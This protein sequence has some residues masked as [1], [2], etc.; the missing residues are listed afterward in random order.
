LKEIGEYLRQAREEKNIS[1]KDVQ[2]ATKISM[3][4]LEAIERGDFNGIPGEVYCKGFIANYA[5]AI[6]LDPQYVLQRYHQIKTEQEEQERQIQLEQAVVQKYNP[7]ITLRWSKE[8]YLTVATSL[9]GLLLI[10]SCIFPT[11][12]YKE[13]NDVF[14][15]RK[16]E[17]KLSDDNQSPQPYPITVYAVFSDRVWIL[18][19]SDG[20]YLYTKDGVT[21]NGSTS[22]QLWTAQKE[23]EVQ[24]G[25]PM[26]VKLNFN[27]KNL[28][29]LGD[30]G[31]EVVLK[32]TP[33][34]L[35]TP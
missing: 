25:N 35:I 9:I 34:G 23:L 33:N 11:V 10:F 5:I 21:F 32:F 19:K 1:I 20:N 6:G 13:V 22:K 16:P 29:R 26:A 28:G 27:G 24:V 2:E 31:K 7:T 15:S 4:Y 18:V 17:V 3:R 30:K 8:V 14:S 12:Q